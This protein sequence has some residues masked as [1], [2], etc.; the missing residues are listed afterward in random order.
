MASRKQEYSHA[1]AAGTRGAGGV[2]ESL[3]L[4]R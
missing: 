2:L 1:K 3:A 4:S